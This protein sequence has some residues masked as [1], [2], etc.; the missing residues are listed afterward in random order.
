MEE[1]LDK[2]LNRLKNT[3][4]FAAQLVHKE[5]TEVREKLNKERINH[6]KNSW[7]AI[8]TN[9]DNVHQAFKIHKMCKSKQSR[10]C[11]STI[12]DANDRPT[13]SYQET[14]QKLFD[15]SFPDKNHPKVN[16]R[17]K[18]NNRNLTYIT[19]NEVS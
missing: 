2:R 8:N 17:T 6:S 19:I 18:I 7:N 4:L 11:P 12:L 10:S 13:S 14:T 1:Q 9:C 16:E 5:L 15:H 3:N